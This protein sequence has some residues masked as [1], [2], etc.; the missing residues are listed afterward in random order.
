MMNKNNWWLIGITA[1]IAGLAMSD[2]L[3]RSQEGTAK[4]QCEYKVVQVGAYRDFKLIEKTLNEHGKDGWEVVDWEP[5]ER[6]RAHRFILK[7]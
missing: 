4:V 7:R 2:R 6:S 1:L 3:G 5:D